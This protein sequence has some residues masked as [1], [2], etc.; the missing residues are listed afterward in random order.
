[1]AVSAT[2]ATNARPG[3]SAA[4]SGRG[5]P[6]LVRRTSLVAAVVEG[7][8]LT[9]EVMRAAAELQTLGAT[10]NR[11]QIVHAAGRLG[12]RAQQYRA[13]FRRLAGDVEE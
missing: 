9:D 2:P 6:D 3:A 5:V 11:A 12:Y 10:G 8:A 7:A 1:M 4:L 13:E